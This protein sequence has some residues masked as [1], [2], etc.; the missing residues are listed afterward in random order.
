MPIVGAQT[1]RSH[2]GLFLG[3]ENADTCNIYRPP[4]AV[5]CGICN[6]CVD[7]FD[8]HCPWVGNCVGRRNYRFF[9][10]FIY[11]VMVKLFY[12]VS[13][14][15]YDFYRR[16]HENISATVPAGA[17]AFR[18]TLKNPAS[19]LLMFYCL[20]ICGFVGILAVFHCKLVSCNTTTNEHVRSLCTLIELNCSRLHSNINNFS[21]LDQGNV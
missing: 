19:F 5:H 2:V 17:D 1:Q 4:R 8:H 20:A 15:I 3:P 18:E 12:C 16:Y 10:T 21:S 13:V 9:L 14:C 7:R 6:N 11:S